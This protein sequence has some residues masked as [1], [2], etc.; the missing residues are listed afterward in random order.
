MNYVITNSVQ[1]VWHYAKEGTK[2]KVVF[3]AKGVP[4]PSNIFKGS[5]VFQGGSGMP[6]ISVECNNNHNIRSSAYDHI[7]TKMFTDIED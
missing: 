1:T 6:L 7:A 2:Y 4:I 5:V 3:Y